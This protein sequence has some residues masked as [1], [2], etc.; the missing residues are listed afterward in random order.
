MVPGVVRCL[1][2]PVWNDAAVIG[3]RVLA[4]CSLIDYID[5][6][7]SSTSILACSSFS[8]HSRLACAWARFLLVSGG[9]FPNMIRTN[10]AP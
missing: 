10:R 4:E 1:L 7:D 3:G 5:R 8:V 2:E 9:S 6:P